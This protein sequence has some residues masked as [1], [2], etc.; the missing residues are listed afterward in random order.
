MERTATVGTTTQVCKMCKRQFDN[1]EL[2]LCFE[3]GNAKV[4]GKFHC[5]KCGDVYDPEDSQVAMGGNVIMWC[6]PCINKMKEEEAA[7]PKCADCGVTIEHGYWLCTY[8]ADKEEGNLP[9]ED[10]GPAFED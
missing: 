7:K 3:C 4:D 1:A 2:A 8:C 10:D 5:V 9:Y 6:I